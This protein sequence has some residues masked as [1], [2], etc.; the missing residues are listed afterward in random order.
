MLFATLAEW[1]CALQGKKTLECGVNRAYM[2][3]V[4]QNMSFDIER[5]RRILGYK[6]VESLADGIRAGVEWYKTDEE[7]Q[8]RKKAEAVEE[9]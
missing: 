7:K 4:L 3:Y 9:R 8:R 1:V 5:A 2:Q 6:P